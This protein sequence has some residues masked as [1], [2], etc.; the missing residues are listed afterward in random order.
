[1]PNPPKWR[2]PF[3][4]F[5]TEELRSIRLV[6]ELGYDTVWLSEHHFAEDGYAPSLLVIAAAVA[7]VTER[8]RIGTSVLLLPLHNPIRVAEDAAVVDLGLGQGYTRE[9]F[10]GYGISP[11][12]AGEPARGG[13]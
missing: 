5:Y 10:E 4:E 3:D 7:A 8:V 1:M 12:R 6:E 2:A 11:E 13:D 9:E